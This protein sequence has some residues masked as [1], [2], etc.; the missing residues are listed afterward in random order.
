MSFCLAK[1]IQEAPPAGSSADLL[2]AQPS[3]STCLTSTLYLGP[4][5]NQSFS[6]FLKGRALQG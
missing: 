6:M 1:G 2:S 5:A 4:L 3:L